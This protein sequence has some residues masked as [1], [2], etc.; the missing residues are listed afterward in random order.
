MTLPWS[1]PESWF[2][3]I[4][5]A[6]TLWSPKSIWPRTGCY[7]LTSSCLNI[8]FETILCVCYQSNPKELHLLVVKGIFHYLKHT[9]KLGLW[10]PHDSEFKLVVYTDFD[11]GGFDIDWNSTSGG[12]QLLGNW[13][14]SLSSK[15]HMIVT[16]SNTEVEYVVAE[17]CCAQ[18]LWIQNRPQDYGF[19]FTNTP[20]WCDNTNTILVI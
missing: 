7:N 2:Y 20:I 12:A 11:H 6:L 18:I 17:R 19:S 5:M 13:L 1:C 16:C 9:Q 8:M 15:K 14:V 10:Y 4:N 3:P